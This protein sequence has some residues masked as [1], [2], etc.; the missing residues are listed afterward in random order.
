MAD[1]SSP[2]GRVV[3]ALV[4]GA[5][6]SIAAGAI[7]ATQ[8]AQEIYVSNYTANTIAVY[9]R[10]AMGDVA[11]TRTIRAGLDHPH[12]LSLDVDTREIFVPNNLIDYDL[13]AVNVYDFDASFPGNDVP[14]RTI[15][16]SLTQLNRPAGILVDTVH[17][18]LYVANDVDFGSSVTVY[19]LNASGNVAP[20]RVLQGGATGINGPI[21][22]AIDD[23]HDELIVACYKVP[24][25]GS[26]LFFP[27][28]ASGNA[29]PLRSIQGPHT[30]LSQPQAIALDLAHDEILVA[31][32]SFQSADPGDILFFARTDR[33]D[34]SPSR[35]I[36]GPTTQ[37][38]NPVGLVLAGDEITVA[39]SSFGSGGCPQ[40]VTTYARTAS[41]DV[42]PLRAIGPGPVSA[43]HHPTGIAV[44][45]QVDCSDPSVTD[46][47]RCDDGNGCTQTDTCQSGVCVG[48][49]PVVCSAPDDCHDAGACDP[50]TGACSQPAKADGT[51]CNDGDSC[52]QSDSCQD[53]VCLGG[54]PV[55]CDDADPCTLDTCDAVTGCAHTFQDADGDTVCD[56]QDCAPNDPGAYAVPGE[57]TALLFGADK[58]TL[59][60]NSETAAAGPG[61]VSDLLRGSTAEF[62]VGSGPAEQCLD[63][64][65]PTP[66]AT[67]TAVPAAD[68]GWWYL[69]RGRNACGQGPYGFASDGGEETSAACP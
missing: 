46:G 23:V 64:G 8:A 49:D 18:E 11:P 65:L 45:T 59:T 1:R 57:V 29:P 9:P 10:D 3:L 28:T 33:D 54:S 16:G 15:S 5:V 7:G 48:A 4:L 56:A 27:R 39:N 12:S 25:G 34:A 38:C 69:V 51:A 53:G 30:E 42:A 67:D 21:G 26:L 62:P 6:V 66:S 2:V 60:W 44:T 14:K 41:G 24:D 35:R 17:Q 47:T 63:S 13:P 40:T 22:L 50:A 58:V 19:P 36:G 32:S 52:T 37:L 55:S 68:S 20:I 43:L 31:N 61:T